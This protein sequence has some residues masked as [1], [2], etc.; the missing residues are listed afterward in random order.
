MSELACVEGTDC[1][2]EIRECVSR[3]SVVV[4]VVEGVEAVVERRGFQVELAGG[5]GDGEGGGGLG[6]VVGWVETFSRSVAGESLALQW[7][8]ALKRRCF[9]DLCYII[10]GNMESLVEMNGFFSGQRRTELCWVE[11]PWRVGT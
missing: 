2:Y 9:M 3:G 11:V 4:D 1:R 6:F 10:S 8:P 5:E 7:L